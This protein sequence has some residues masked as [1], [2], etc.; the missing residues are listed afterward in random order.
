MKKQ[1]LLNAM[2]PIVL[3]VVLMFVLLCCPGME[4]TALAANGDKTITGLGTGVIRNPVSGS[5]GWNYVYYGKYNNKPVKYRVLDK[6]STAFGGNTMLLDCDSTLF[7]SAFDSSSETSNVWKTSKLRS[8]LN[9]PGFYLNKDVFTAAEKNAIWASTKS[10]TSKKDGSGTLWHSFA[11]LSGEWVFLL[12]AVEATSSAYGYADKGKGNN[13]EYA[14]ETRKKTGAS[15]E[16]WLRS[17]DFTYNKYVGYVHDE[18]R[19]Y[20]SITNYEHT[21]VSPAFNVNLSS[22]IFS[23]VVPS[24]SGSYKLTLRDQNLGISDIG[25]ITREGKTI[26]VPC[27]VSGVYNRVS[28]LMTDK[29]WNESNA[30]VKYYGKLDDSNQFTLPDDYDNSWAVYILAEKVNG[31]KESDYASIPVKI[32]IQEDDQKVPDVKIRTGKTDTSPDPV[33]PNKENYYL[34]RIHQKK[35]KKNRITITWTKVPGAN[36][37]TIYGLMCNKNRRMKKIGT[38]KKTSFTYK[39]L[40][41]GRYYKF[42]VAAKKGKK[43]IATSTVIHIATT[44]GKYGNPASVKVNKNKLTLQVKK[45]AAL[46]AAVKNKGKV[47]VHKERALAYESTNPKIAKVN[48]NGRVTAAAKGTC[49]VYVYA[50]NGIS[51]KVKVTVR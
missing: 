39:K 48:K 13:Y 18:G 7:A 49:Y 42:Y 38:V 26:K 32:T 15:A 14:A 1:I 21:G 24:E 43:K 9:G 5:G 6:A 45:T 12:D 35:A 36:S 51:A 47:S 31:E 11:P 30:K 27:S 34:F 10:Q 8:S 17:P 3:A 20:Y 4:N 44:G 16:W 22:V 37:Y 19:F 23:S 29:A 25:S 33:D 46:K 50:Q 40:K 28:V 2:Q 41:R